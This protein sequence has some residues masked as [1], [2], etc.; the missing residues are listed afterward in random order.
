[1]KVTWTRDAVEA[2]GPTTNV[3]TAASILGIGD[4]L[5]YESIQRDEWPTRVL[6]LGNRILVP[7]V[8]LLALLFAPENSEA[9][10]LAT[11][12]VQEDTTDDTVSRVSSPLRTVRTGA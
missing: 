6:R 1:M 11:A 8:D 4:R 3:R 9:E 2:L 12:H 7:T 10:A 5:A